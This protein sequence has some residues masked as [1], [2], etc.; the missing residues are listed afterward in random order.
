MKSP[1]KRAVGKAFHHHQERPS[2][3]RRRRK[4]T[5]T[6]YLKRGRRDGLQFTSSLLGDFSSLFGKRKKNTTCLLVKVLLDF[7]AIKCLH[8]VLVRGLQVLDPT[9]CKSAVSECA[10]GILK[11][12]KI[13]QR[14]RRKRRTKKSSSLTLNRKASTLDS[15]RCSK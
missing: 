7:L 2:P 1:K 15:K 8:S 14:G 5:K 13:H 4:A 6:F 10:K 9:H 3:C 12:E 11:E